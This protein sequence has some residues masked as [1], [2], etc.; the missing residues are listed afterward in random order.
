MKAYGTE[1][2][3]I[4]FDRDEG[5]DSAAAKVAERLAAEG[6]ICWRVLFPRPAWTPTS[7]R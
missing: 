1:R 6:I 4:A 7:T 2:V 3:L 5:G